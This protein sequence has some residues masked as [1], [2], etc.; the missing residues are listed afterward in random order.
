MSDFIL[1]AGHGGHDSG[2]TGNGYKE[3]DLTLKVCKDVKRKLDKTPLDVKIIRDA[4]YYM[5]LHKIAEEANRTNARGFLSVHFNSAANNSAKGIETFH[6]ENSAK[7][8]KLA[9]EIQTLLIKNNLGLADRGVKTANFAVLRL[10][11]MPAALLEVCFINN[12]KDLDFFLD[13]YDKYIN[14]IAQSILDYMN[15][16]FTINDKNISKPKE[17]PIKVID[18]KINMMLLAE[19]V[20]VD[21]FIKEGTSYVKIN[22]SFISIREIL[23]NMSLTVGWDNKNRII[24]ADINKEFKP[25]KDSVKIML[26]GNMINVNAINKENKHCLKIEN[27]YIPI[28]NIFETLG[29]KVSWDNDNKIIK[30]NRG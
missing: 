17:N 11:K 27:A 6:H 29:F 9:N 26:L 13:N 8:K 20:A 10:T 5:P 7:G 15:I 22:D 1:N 18:N 14:S 23:E 30:I 12:K 2:A 21:G 4:D 16:N 25:N 19:H 24:T 3:K 28:R